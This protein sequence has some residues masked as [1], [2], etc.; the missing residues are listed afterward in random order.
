VSWVILSSRASEHPGSDTPIE[1]GMAYVTK[2]V[3]TVM[4]GPLWERSAI[5][6]TWDDWG[7]F[8]DH[9]PPPRIDENGYGLRV[10][11]ITIS[12]WVKG[13]TIDHQ[14]LTFDAYLKLIED[15]YLDGERLDPETLSRP[16]SRPTVREDVA[17]LGD[18]LN[19]FD[20]EQEPL[21]PVILPLRPL[22][23]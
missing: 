16:D 9:V 7:G 23:A 2:L 4:R 12:P 8:Y 20:F 17:R 13:G 10:P 19:E 3:N 6:L 15:L 1:D 18:L 22:D 21:D 11:G 14:T 5:F